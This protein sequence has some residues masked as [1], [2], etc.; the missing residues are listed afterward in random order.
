MGISIIAVLI[1]VFTPL[2]SGKVYAFNQSNF[3]FYPGNPESTND[4]RRA[5]DAFNSDGNDYNEAQNWGLFEVYIK[6]FAGA[7]PVKLGFSKED[8]ENFNNGTRRQP[9]FSFTYYCSMPGGKISLSNPGGDPASLYEI[10]YAIILQDNGTEGLSFMK[11]DTYN[12]TGGILNVKVTDSKYSQ[13][14]RWNAIGPTDPKG[15]ANGDQNA[16]KEGTGAKFGIDSSECQPPA[17]TIGNFS[18]G[19][20]II[21]YNKLSESEKS[22]FGEAKK[23]QNTG[24]GSTGSN[25]ANCDIQLSNLMSWILCPV[26][27]TSLS[28]THF[29]F[30][31]IVS[32]FLED[33]PVTTDPEDASYTAWKNFRLLGNIV[34]VGTMM[35]VVYAQVKGGR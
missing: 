33:V 32:P 17:S 23:T 9:V 30:T 10:R 21:N 14:E 35:A 15:I 24:D 25:E 12:G 8:S 28:A 26:I 7:G 2:I 5:N 20:G 31:K 29:M 27:D 1:T 34:L 11:R 19:S 22:K 3:A 13:K 6:D 4:Q 18:G 16:F